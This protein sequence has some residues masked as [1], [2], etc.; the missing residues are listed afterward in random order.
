MPLVGYDP[1]AAQQQCLPGDNRR[2]GIRQV[3]AAIEVR[4]NRKAARQE[5]FYSIEMLCNPKRALTN[6]RAA[7]QP[8]AACPFWVRVSAWVVDFV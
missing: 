7:I 4:S 5:A 2:Q 6:V 1:A 3:H 8:L